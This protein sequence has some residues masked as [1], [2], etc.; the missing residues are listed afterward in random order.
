ML[1]GRNDIRLKGLIP[2]SSLLAIGTILLAMFVQR[3]SNVFYTE[4]DK[5]EYLHVFPFNVKFYMPSFIIFCLGAITLVMNTFI[6]VFR[7][8]LDRQVVK[9]ISLYLQML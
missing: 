5:T 7:R 9:K 6:Y 4:G 1:Y 8:D 2:P 3:Y